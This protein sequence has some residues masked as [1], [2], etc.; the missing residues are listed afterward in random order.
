M[1]APRRLLDADVAEVVFLPGWRE[2]GRRLPRLLVGIL[3][4]GVGIG[5]MYRARLGLSPWD[6]LHEGVSEL[7]GLD[8]GT[9]VIAVG[10]LILLAWIPLHQRFGL[11]TVINTICVGIVINITI[12]AVDQPDVLAGRVAFLVGG[13]VIVGFGTGLYISAGL[14][15][16]PCDGLMTAIA[17]LGF[18]VWLVRTVLELS[19]LAAG[20]ALGGD[21]GAGT[22]VFVFAIGPL[23]HV[24]LSLLRL[25]PAQPADL[26][27][28]VTAE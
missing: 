14:G 23:A 12:A 5:F 19:A 13:I 2:L 11:G 26:G 17:A 18:P 20:W 7:T 15:P 8:F 28:G 25:P 16:V 24:F 10:A 3:C 6:V 27:P 22:L 1:S 9:V 21:V 4:L